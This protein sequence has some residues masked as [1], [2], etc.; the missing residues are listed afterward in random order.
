[1]RSIKKQLSLW[2]IVLITCVMA[3]AIPVAAGVPI[4]PIRPSVPF[5]QGYWADRLERRLD[6]YEENEDAE[7]GNA[8]DDEKAGNDEEDAE[9]DLYE[10]RREYWRDRLEDEDW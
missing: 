2:R 7:G 4:P 1:M 3:V 9:D 10:Q 5:Q 6:H 8:K